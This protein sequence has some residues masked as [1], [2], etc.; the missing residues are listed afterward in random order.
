MYNYTKGFWMLNI[1]ITYHL[2]SVMKI[3]SI[4]QYF[5]CNYILL[6]ILTFVILQ[7]HITSGVHAIGVMKDYLE[8]FNRI[9]RM[10]MLWKVIIVSMGILLIFL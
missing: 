7:L 9:K 10:R 2:S 6:C 5:F 3:I 1:Q 4:Y 8:E